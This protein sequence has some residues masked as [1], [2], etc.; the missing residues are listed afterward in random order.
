M[1]YKT[2]KSLLSKALGLMFSRKRNLLFVFG[3]ERRI[4]LHNWFVFYPINLVFLDKNK[5]VVEIKR[6]FKP[7]CFYASKRKARYLIETPF[8]VKFK[9]GNKIK[10]PRNI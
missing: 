2:C 6:D 1:R 8:E 9:L 3:K 5:R 7:F 4:M 10:I